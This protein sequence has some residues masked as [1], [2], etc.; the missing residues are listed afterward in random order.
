MRFAHTL[1]LFYE[2]DLGSV[3]CLEYFI[4]PQDKSQDEV[5]GAHGYTPQYMSQ[6]T[7]TFTSVDS[8]F[9][10]QTI[11]TFEQCQSHIV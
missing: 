5:L 1:Y 6:V 11:Q 8:I 10:Q 2:D 7:F 3:T 9:K 4:P